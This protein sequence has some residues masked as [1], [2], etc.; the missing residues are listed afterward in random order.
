MNTLSFA[1]ISMRF[2][3]KAMPPQS[4]FAP[5]PLTWVGNRY[6]VLSTAAEHWY[7][8]NGTAD[9]E[10]LSLAEWQGKGFDTAGTRV[11]I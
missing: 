11:L 10:Q 6:H 8:P 4:R 9:S 1:V 2:L 7:W 3:W 5:A